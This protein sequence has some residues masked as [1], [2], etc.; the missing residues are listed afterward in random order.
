MSPKNT[1][2]TNFKS[3]WITLFILVAVKKLAAVETQKMASP[4]VLAAKGA[5]PTLAS[6]I[7]N[8]TRISANVLIAVAK[9][10]AV[11]SK[12]MH[13]SSACIKVYV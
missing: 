13:E 4:V 5:I 7:A 12:F 8:V 9:I 3:V 2:T 10:N 6:A 1:L 11:T